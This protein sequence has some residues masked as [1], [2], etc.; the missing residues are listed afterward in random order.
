MI[1]S[2]WSVDNNWTLFLDRDGVINERLV[3]DYVKN[4]EE[5]SFIPGSKEAIVRFSKLFCRIVVVTNQQG[6]GKGFMNEDDLAKVHQYMLNEIK[7]AGGRIDA[8][9]FCPKLASENAA[10]RK[11]NTGM[12]LR[13]Q[14]FFPEIN[15]DQSIMVGDSVSDIEMGRRLNMKTVFINENDHH[16]ADFRINSLAE[17]K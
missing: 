9:Y 5:F 4:V 16:F 8:V 15:F 2:N 3:G 6:I 12:A 17:L 7:N 13:A 10:C 1:F 14:S 11:P